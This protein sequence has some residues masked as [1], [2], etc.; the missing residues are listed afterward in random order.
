MGGIFGR[1]S[2]KTSRQLEIT[3]QDR[4]VLQL[5]QQRDLLNQNRRRIEN[6]IDRGREVAKQL[7]KNGQQDRALL[8]LR[9]KKMLEMQL[10]K[11]EG[12]LENVERMTH[13]LEFAQVQ[14][15]VV[16]SLRQGTDALKKMNELLKID[17]IERLM[18]DSR[19]AIEYQKEVSNLLAGGLN[20]VDEENIEAELEELIHAEEAREINR[21]PDVP[22]NRQRKLF[23]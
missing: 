21:L 22:E 3:E 5:K 13:E 17:D 19:E 15:T 23:G 12:I 7:L 20:R 4:A 2:P 8:L 18:E 10:H 14:A 6:Q 1:K 16:S 9:K 11:T